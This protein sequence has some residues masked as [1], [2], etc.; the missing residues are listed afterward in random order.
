MQQK[1]LTRSY[2]TPKFI[3][4]FIIILFYRYF[5]LFF[6]NYDCC[7]ISVSGF[8]NCITLL[9]LFVYL[10]YASKFL[11]P[12]RYPA[13]VRGMLTVRIV[14]SVKSITIIYHQHTLKVAKRVNVIHLVLL[15]V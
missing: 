5:F 7:I 2:A 3:I 6:R 4:L 12:V 8:I 14:Q 9:V 13:Y 1:N 11:T 10:F 15:L